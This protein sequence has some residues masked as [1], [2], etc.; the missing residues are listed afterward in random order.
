MLKSLPLWGKSLALL[1]IFAFFSYS[2]WEAYRQGLIDPAL[3]A[4]YKD[5]HPILAVLLFLLI[6]V[7]S[8]IFMLPTLPL[9]LAGG[10]FWG[11]W[12]GGFY[13]TVGVTLGAWVSFFMARH[14]I[15][16]PLARKIDNAWISRV[17]NGFDRQGWQFLLF[18]RMNPVLPPGPLSYVFG[19]TAFPVST[20]LAITFA[21]LLLPATGVAFVGDVL[22]TFTLQ[23]ENHAALM[24]AII[25]ASVILTVAWGARLLFKAPK[26]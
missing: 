2:G 18:V 20:F 16:T 25:L 9:N 11:G 24:Q 4:A 7:F 26:K 19:L 22:Q 5:S 1:A 8:V 15:G 21:C 13:T 10:V 23:P 12:L 17:Q 14:I 3:I 6:Y